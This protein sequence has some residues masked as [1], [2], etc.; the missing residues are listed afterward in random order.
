MTIQDD[1]VDSADDKRTA[2]QLR[3]TVALAATGFCLL[4]AGS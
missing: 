4:T 3:K 2:E 1:L